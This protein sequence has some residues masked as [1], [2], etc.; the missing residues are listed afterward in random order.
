MSVKV[1]YIQELVILNDPLS[2]QKVVKR[3]TL[4][5]FAWAQTNSVF[6]LITFRYK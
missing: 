3:G 4:Y 2:K 5:L 1:I 6:T